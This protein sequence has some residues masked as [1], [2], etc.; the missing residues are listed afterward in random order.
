[1]HITVGVQF[2]ILGLFFLS[3]VFN[4][5][6]VDVLGGLVVVLFPLS[7]AIGFGIHLKSAFATSPF[8]AVALPLLCSL[9]LIRHKALKDMFTRLS[10]IRGDFSDMKVNPLEYFSA[11][12][13]ALRRPDIHIAVSRQL[14]FYALIISLMLLAMLNT[15]F[16]VDSNWVS[17]MYQMSNDGVWTSANSGPSSTQ[18]ESVFFLFGSVAV[19]SVVSV[20][21]LIISQLESIWRQR[22]QSGNKSRKLSALNGAIIL[23]GLVL[24]VCIGVAYIVIGITMFTHRGANLNIPTCTFAMFMLVQ[25]TFFITIASVSGMGLPLTQLDKIYGGNIHDILQKEIE[26]VR[27]V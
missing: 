17:T 3:G 12:F 14:G 2:V 11:R 21:C 1:M 22:L 24:V 7:C 19:L 18:L 4:H 8:L 9:T 6:I 20:L 10:H 16:A 5:S 23:F 26:S 15:A 13:S 25:S 27:K